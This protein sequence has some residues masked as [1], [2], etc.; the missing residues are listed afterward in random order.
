MIVI[1]CDPDADGNWYAIYINGKLEQMIQWQLTD[2]IKYILDSKMAKVD[3]VF[4]IENVMV[5]TFVYS[6]N[7]QSSKAAQSKIAMGIGRCQQAQVELQR[8]LDHYEITYQL[9]KPTRDNWAK[10]KARFEKVT[11]WSGRSNA[12]GR[13]AAYFGYLLTR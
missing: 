2:V 7:V 6:R 8:V 9:V 13:S 3:L 4:S 1:G 11:G 12:D 5:N 10:D